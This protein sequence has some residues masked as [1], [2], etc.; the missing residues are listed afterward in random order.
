MSEL[1]RYKMTV[2][3]R[4]TA[5]HG[6]QQQAVNPTWKKPLPPAGHGI[7]TVQEKLQRAIVRVVK[8]PVVCVG[9]SRTD[10]GVHAKG[11]LVH[12]DTDKLD[13]PT[14]SLRRA[15]NHQLPDDILVRA[16]DPVS[17]KYDAILST[18]SKRYQYVIWNQEDRPP[19]MGDLV[20]HRWKPMDY[21]VMREAARHLVGT[22]DFASFARP[23]HKRANT[24]RTLLDFDISWRHPRLVFGV[25]GR[26]FLWHMVRIM[27]GTL[28]DVGLGRFTPDDIPRM[29]EAR[30]RR[31]AGLTAPPNGLYLQW[32]R[33]G[34]DVDRVQNK[35]GQAEPE[36]DEVDDQE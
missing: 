25:E 32:I 35:A 8:H 19:F 16:I 17:P 31:A 4:G 21:A 20:W 29:L 3:Y 36:P 34:P 7:P 5:Y 18:F 28:V 1:Q 9:S 13:I 27:V 11:Q 26:G 14:D 6:W 2:A 23:G 30:D 15:I 22:H 12:F 33:P 24:V 10:A